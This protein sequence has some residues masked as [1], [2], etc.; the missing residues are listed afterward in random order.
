[1]PHCI[2]SSM[3]MARERIDEQSDL[4]LNGATYAPNGSI[5]RMLGL[6]TADSIW[7]I[8]NLAG[9]VKEEAIQ[10]PHPCCE[11]RSYNG[12]LLLQRHFFDAHSIEEPRRNC[13]SWKRKWICEF[14]ACNEPPSKIVALDGKRD[15]SLN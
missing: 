9:R 3:R 4:F 1:M 14:D 11:N 6:S 13:V 12:I 2:S 10:C 7:T 5:Q 8:Y 15:E